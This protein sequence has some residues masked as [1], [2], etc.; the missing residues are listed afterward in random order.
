V[1]ASWKVDEPSLLLNR[2]E[3]CG[4]GAA[5]Y[6]DNATQ[7]AIHDRFAPLADQGNFQELAL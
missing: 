4:L 7:H 5:G 3:I 1:A 2:L 6:S